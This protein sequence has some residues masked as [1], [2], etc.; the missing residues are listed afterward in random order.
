MNESNNKTVTKAYLFWLFG[1]LFGLHHIYLHRDKQAIVCFSTFGSFLIGLLLDIFNIPHY[2]REYNEDIELNQQL[3]KVRSRQKTPSFR[4]SSFIASILIG[5]FTGYITMHCFTE[6]Y[7]LTLF[8]SKCWFIF[9]AL[10]IYLINTE[11][12]IKCDIKWPLIGAFIGFLLDNYYSTYS[13]MRCSLFSTLFIN[14]KME[15][16]T[17]DYVKQKKQQNIKTRIKRS[18]KLTF[19]YCLVIAIYFVYF[20]NNSSIYVDGQYMSIKESY[21]KFKESQ[22]FYDIKRNLLLIWNYYRAHGFREFFNSFIYDTSPD[23]LDK[24]YKVTFFLLL[25]F[26]FETIFKTK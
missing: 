10:T 13:G 6:N 18:G 9:T 4:W 3:T 22:I 5:S 16:N 25:S 11:G 14:W 12:P 2:V 19:G 8:F 20:W 17:H 1:G 21:Y 24:A 15:W 23:A 26:S 7:Y